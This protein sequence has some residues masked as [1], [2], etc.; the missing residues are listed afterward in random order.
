MTADD[1]APTPIRDVEEV[2]H[3]FSNAGIDI[4]LDRIKD[5][6]HFSV[7]FKAYPMGG[8]QLVRTRWATDAWMKAKFTDRLG[9][10]V[11]PCGSTPSIFTIS[12]DTVAASTGTAPVVQPERD[13]NVFRPAE[14]P[15]LVLS[16]DLKD[17]ER[18]FR[19]I[20]RTDPGH[21]DFESVLN[22]E[23]P[24]GRRLQ[25]IVNF[26]LEEL[27][28]HPSALDNPIVRRQLDDLVLAGILSFPGAHHR[29]IER[30]DGSVGAAVVR[31]AEEFMEANVGQPI[32]MSDVA[33]ACG[34]SRT[35]LFLAFQQE[36]EWTPLQF[37]VRRRMEW[38]RRALLTPTRRMTVTAVALD[39]GYAS[40]SRFAQEYRKLFGETPSVTLNRSR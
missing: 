18:L 12:G 22:L 20:T 27:T 36:R 17:L 39:C 15:L 14:T 8:T 26:A 11:N 3:A 6:K 33:A 13:I 35:K 2:V 30:S 9:V 7:E 24:A 40:V 19:D 28:A 29:L 31:R 10:I 16:A 5:Q 34:C 23:T 21:L 4:R 1:P 32:G 38:A 25:R 37:L